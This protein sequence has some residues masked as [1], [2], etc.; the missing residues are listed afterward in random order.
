MTPVE[1]NPP[2]SLS[3]REVIAKL[4]R[5]RDQTYSDAALALLTESGCAIRRWRSDGC[6]VA[7]LRSPDWAISVPPPSSPSAYFVLAHEVGHQVLHRPGSGRPR[8][9][10]WEEEIEADEYAAET[11]TRFGLPDLRQ[12]L[13]S[14]CEYLAWALYKSLRSSPRWRERLPAMEERIRRGPLDAQLGGLCLDHWMAIHLPARWR[15]LQAGLC[16]PRA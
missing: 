5:M 2:P 14:Q 11:F 13:A 9:L 4:D 16:G 6:G 10:R 3:A 12:A 15:R 1:L 7:H 8:V